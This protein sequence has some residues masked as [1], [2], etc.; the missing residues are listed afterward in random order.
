MTFLATINAKEYA[1][2]ASDRME[3]AGIGPFS[4]CVSKE[5]TKI[6]STGIGLMTGTGY[7]KLL[8]N[9]KVAV[10]NAEISHTEQIIAIIKDNCSIIRGETSYPLT[11]NEDLIN[12]TAWLFTYFT[13]QNENNL[14]RVALYCPNVATEHLGLVEDFKCYAFFPSDSTEK[15]RESTMATLNAQVVWPNNLNNIENTLSINSSLILKLMKNVSQSS[16]MVTESCDIGL[17][18]LNGDMMLARNVSIQSPKISFES[19]N[20]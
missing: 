12:R 15:L 14:I 9:V 4:I 16:S 5:V 18:F 2:I 11:D 3:V 10:S 6:V 13:H 1:L 20:S 19:I 8:D 17:V 7:V